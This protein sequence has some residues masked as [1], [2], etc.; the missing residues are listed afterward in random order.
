MTHDPRIDPATGS[1]P[2]IGFD[3]FRCFKC[4]RVLTRLQVLAGM[5]RDGGHA[6]PCGSVQINPSN[7]P[8]AVMEG[9][10]VFAFLLYM[11]T[12]WRHWHV[13]KF[14]VLRTLGKA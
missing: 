11:L 10:S 1:D 9:A 13:W 6:C 8:E 7:G 14:T 5:Q 2:L 4:H 3:F 12:P